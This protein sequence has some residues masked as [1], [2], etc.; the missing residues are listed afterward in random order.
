[1]EFPDV[2]LMPIRARRSTPVDMRKVVVY[3]FPKGVYVG[4]HKEAIRFNE[5]YDEFKR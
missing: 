3:F 2:E 5:I 1:M 4:L